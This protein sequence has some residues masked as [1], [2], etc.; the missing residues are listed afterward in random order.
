LRRYE[1]STVG[2]TSFKKSTHTPKLR[3]SPLF[4]EKSS[5]ALSQLDATAVV[6]TTGYELSRIAP[7]AF[8]SSKAG[9]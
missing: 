9:A 8:Y 5:S 1:H 7:S 6:V 2:N 4:Y 3:P